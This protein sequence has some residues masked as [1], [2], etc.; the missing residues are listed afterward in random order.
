MIAELFHRAPDSVGDAIAGH[1]FE[2][3]PE[4]SEAVAHSAGQRRPRDR[5]RS[6]PE[7]FGKRPWGGAPRGRGDLGHAAKQT[8]LRAAA[9]QHRAILPSE[10]ERDAMAQR[11]LRLLAPRG[12]FFRPVGRRSSAA[13]PPRTE[14]AA[15]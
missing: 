6:G 13:G 4:M 3:E 15:R 10:P 11:P 2:L 9:K 5:G 8:F 1:N 14:D 12:Q 7:G